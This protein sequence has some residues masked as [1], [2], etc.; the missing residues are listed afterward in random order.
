MYS[1]TTQSSSVGRKTRLSNG[2][3][4]AASKRRDVGDRVILAATT[5]RRL[6]GRDVLVDHK[7]PLLT[8][9]PSACLMR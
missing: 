9:W 3:T 8:G 4:S 5:K 6:D 1:S 7:G 2:P